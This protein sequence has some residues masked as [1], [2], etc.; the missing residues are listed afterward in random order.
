[1]AK[2]EDALAISLANGRREDIP[3]ETGAVVARKRTGKP[4]EGGRSH[5]VGFMFFSNVGGVKLG[6]GA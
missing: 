6:D 3:Q 1:M 4:P 2:T 5:L